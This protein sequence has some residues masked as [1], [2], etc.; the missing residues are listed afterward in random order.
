ML[1]DLSELVALVMFTA[2]IVVVGAILFSA[3]H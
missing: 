3:V 2:T 1:R